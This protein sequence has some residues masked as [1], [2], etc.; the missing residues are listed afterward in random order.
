M[1]E[2]T[3]KPKPKRRWLRFN[4]RSFLIV[5]TI[6]SAWVGWYVYR[7]EKQRTTVQWVQENGG[8]VFYDCQFGDARN[9]MGDPQPAVPKRLLD[10]LGVDYFSSVT[11]VVID[12]QELSDVTPLAHLKNLKSL[13][14]MNTQV[15]D[16]SPLAGLTRLE[17]LGLDALQVTDEENA[18]KALPNCRIDY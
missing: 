2:L 18:K 9:F 12:D 6:L 4:L 3:E 10:M 14:L 17:Y 8:S 1:T 15:R 16:L 7:A 11:L 13:L 5:I